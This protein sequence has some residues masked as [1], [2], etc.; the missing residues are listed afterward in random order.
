LKSVE[1]ERKY[2]QTKKLRDA[3]LG[4]G[5]LC[6][7]WPAHAKKA[8]GGKKAKAAEE[9]AA[10]ESLEEDDGGMDMRREDAELEA[11]LREYNNEGR[12]RKP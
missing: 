11:M 12:D 2:Q 5:D 4:D 7:D 1:R 9:E 8:A 10:E 3:L 6:D